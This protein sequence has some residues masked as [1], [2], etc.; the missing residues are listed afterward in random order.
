[1]GCCLPAF[2]EFA[3]A[4]LRQTLCHRSL[5][6]GSG[7]SSPVCRPL[8]SSN[9]SPC[10]LPRCHHHPRSMLSTECCSRLR[11][12]SL[13]P[14]PFSLSFGRPQQQKHAPSSLFHVVPILLRPS[15]A[16]RP[17]P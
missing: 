7:Q 2:R 6:L 4:G 16:T 1:M 8:C 15:F 10:S 3:S 5:A 9:L 11:T 12:W 17:P 14:R 13:S